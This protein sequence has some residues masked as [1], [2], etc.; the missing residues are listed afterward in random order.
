MFLIAQHVS[1]DTSVIFGGSKTV[2]AAS[3]LHASVV[4]GRW[5]RPER[6]E[7]PATTDVCKPEAANTVFE[8]LMMSDVSLETC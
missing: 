2:F 5:P 1:S 8:L 6:P 7:R 3:G 4:A